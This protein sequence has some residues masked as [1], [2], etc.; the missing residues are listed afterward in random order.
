MISQDFSSESYT[1]YPKHP[2]ITQTTHV[3]VLS[4]AE[5]RGILATLGL[6]ARF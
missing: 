6:Q 1:I 5:L 3:C 2:T 4:A